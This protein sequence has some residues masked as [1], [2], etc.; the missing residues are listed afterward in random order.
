MKILN[1]KFEIE[2]SDPVFGFG[3]K[4]YN[5]QFLT[6]KQANELIMNGCSLIK[7]TPKASKRPSEKA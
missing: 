4:F 1:G 2:V 3:G 6:K 5:A 7:P